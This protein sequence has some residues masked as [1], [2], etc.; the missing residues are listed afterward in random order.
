[1]SL[2]LTQE[3]DDPDQGL[4]GWTRLGVNDAALYEIDQYRGGGFVYKGL[5]KGR[6]RDIDGISLAQ[7]RFSKPTASLI[8]AQNPMR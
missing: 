8:R 6:D 5:I 2:S 4:G 3:K 7:A 1:M